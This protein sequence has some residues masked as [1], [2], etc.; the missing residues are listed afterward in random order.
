MEKTVNNTIYKVVKQIDDLLTVKAL[1]GG[2][3]VEVVF[4]CLKIE[5]ES[6]FVYVQKRLK[7]IVTN[8]NNSI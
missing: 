2:N 6:D 7:E 5:W 1:I 3:G 4:Y 8:C